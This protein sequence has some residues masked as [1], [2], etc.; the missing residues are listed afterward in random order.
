MDSVRMEQDERLDQPFPTINKYSHNFPGHEERMKAHRKR[1]SA[2]MTKE[3]K[4]SEG[5]K[6]KMS[7]AHKK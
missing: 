1:V 6:R 2:G 4:H 7:R 3:R 5:A